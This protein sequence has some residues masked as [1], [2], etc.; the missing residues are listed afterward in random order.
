MEKARRFIFE[1]YCRIHN[2]I[3]IKMLAE[4]LDMDQDNAEEWVVALIR[5]ARLDAKIDSKA[6][7]VLMTPQ[8]PSIYHQV[9]EKTKVLSSTSDNRMEGDFQK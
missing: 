2:T 3:S 5:N 4:K 8:V 6:G 9:I 1:T 7:H